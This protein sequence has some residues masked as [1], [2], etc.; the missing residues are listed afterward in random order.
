MLSQK[1]QNPLGLGSVSFPLL[2]LTLLS[3]LAQRSFDTSQ[4]FI[5]FHG[6][7]LVPDHH[8]RSPGQL[9][10]PSRC[11][12]L[13]GIALLRSTPHPAPWVMCPQH[14]NNCHPC[15]EAFMLLAMTWPSPP[16]TPLP[17]LTSSKLTDL[18]P[19]SPTRWANVRLR[20]SLTLLS[21]LLGNLCPP[22]SPRSVR[23]S[24]SPAVAP[25]P[26]APA[27]PGSL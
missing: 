1:A 3:S 9:Q 26:A 23:F 25:R 27:S 15:F 2:R 21:W 8:R 20:P 4:P 10:S 16:T 19:T 18:L 12:P 6:H 5:H 11:F 22:S 24:G 7:H 13:P 14:R 17:L